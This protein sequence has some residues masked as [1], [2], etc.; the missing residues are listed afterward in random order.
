MTGEATVVAVESN[1]DI[2]FEAERVGFESAELPRD[3]LFNG[4]T[5]NSLI[6]IYH[7]LRVLQYGIWTIEKELS[8]LCIYTL[9]YQTCDSISSFSKQT[10]LFDS[11]IDLDKFTIEQ[12]GTRRNGRDPRCLQYWVFRHRTKLEAWTYKFV[13]YRLS[14]PIRTRNIRTNI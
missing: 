5:T 8:L 9:R 1:W 6:E 7:E 2:D 12:A 13:N 10:C 4:D 11:R 14:S 3:D